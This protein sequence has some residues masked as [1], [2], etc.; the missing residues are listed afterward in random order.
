MAFGTDIIKNLCSESR[1]FRFWGLKLK[2][3]PGG[4]FPQT[5]LEG[6]AFGAR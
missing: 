4:A 1:K 6:I 3:F 2:K 5:P